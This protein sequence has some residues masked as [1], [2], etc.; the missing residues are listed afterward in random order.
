M[1]ER[2]GFVSGS[3]E[4]LCLPSFSYI[5]HT[6]KLICMAMALSRRRVSWWRGRQCSCQQ[7]YLSSKSFFNLYWLISLCYRLPLTFSFFPQGRYLRPKPGVSTQILPR[8]HCCPLKGR[9]LILFKH[10]VYIYRIDR[11]TPVSQKSIN[12]RENPRKVLF[13][14]YYGNTNSEI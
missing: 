8:P 2:A 9:N 5:S 10:I 4:Q 14:Y 13:Y 6:H 3:I 7:V 11:M 1:E 12:S